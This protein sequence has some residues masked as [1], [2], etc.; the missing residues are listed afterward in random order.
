[1]GLYRTKPEEVEA[2][3]YTGSAT[4][5]FEGNIPQW[6]WLAMVN[7][8]LSFN[9]HGIEIKYNGL[10]EMVGPNDW[11]VLAADGIIRAA[12][13]RVFKQYYLPTRKR[14]TKAEMEEEAAAQ[15]E[16]GV[17]AVATAAE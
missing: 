6:F 14:R 2:I 5:P 11:L 3:Q 13:D 10:S 9:A 8:I 15:A 1:M 4:A 17:V 12:E 7:G 16:A